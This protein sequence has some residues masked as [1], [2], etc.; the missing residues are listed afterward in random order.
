MPR[1]N[2]FTLKPQGGF[3]QRLHQSYG[4]EEGVWSFV[5]LQVTIAAIFAGRASRP[6][7]LKD[8]NFEIVAAAQDTGGEA[9]AGRWYDQAQATYTTLVETRHS[10]SSAYQF[11][12]V[13]M[14]VQIDE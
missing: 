8:R 7:R 14:G 1:I 12:N 5:E 2:R 4:T 11:I 13:P 9:A 6:S 3:A 10:V